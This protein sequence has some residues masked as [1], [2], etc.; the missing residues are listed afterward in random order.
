VPDPAETFRFVK[1][2]AKMTAT[3]GFG[4]PLADDQV[5]QLVTFLNEAPGMK[6]ANF[7][8]RTGTRATAQA[9]EK[10]ASG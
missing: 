3:P 6:P 4:P 8:L 9:N 2:G 1:Y 5:W 7:T 10:F